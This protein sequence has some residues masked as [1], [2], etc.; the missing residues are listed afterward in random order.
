M[1]HRKILPIIL[2]AA[3]GALLVGFAVKTCTDYANYTRAVNSAPFML[4]TAVNALC[5]ITPAAVIA[6]A[7]LFILRRTRALGIVTLVLAALSV[8]TVIAFGLADGLLYAIP[9]ALPALISAV[10]TAVSRRSTRK[11]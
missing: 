6:N 1:K 3:S 11:A 9:F 4:W 7:G 10:L 8:L 5:F 2:F